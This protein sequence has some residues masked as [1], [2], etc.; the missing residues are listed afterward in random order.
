MPNVKVY[1]GQSVIINFLALPINGGL[2]DG[3]FLKI[4]RIS[5]A[6]TSK[7]GVDGE[8]TR[9]KTGDKRVTIELTLM[10]T[11][12]MN[13]ALSA[14]ADTDEKFPNGA[15]IGPFL[16]SSNNSFTFCEKCWIAKRP[17]KTYG[18]EAGT[19]VWKF[20]GVVASELDGEG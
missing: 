16:A 9:S 13:A 3:E 17:D 19:R 20:E 14:F 2:A 11:S 15:G 4:A 6:F 18:K 10:Q 12:A 8:V 1:D 7:A 5:D